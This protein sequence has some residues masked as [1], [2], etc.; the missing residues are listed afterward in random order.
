MESIRQSQELKFKAWYPT[1]GRK[2]TFCPD[3]LPF[4]PSIHS[5]PGSAIDFLCVLRRVKTHTHT[6][7]VGI[8]SSLEKIISAL[9][10]THS[11]THLYCCSR[12]PSVPN[13]TLLTTIPLRRNT[14]WKTIIIII[15]RWMD[16]TD[17]WRNEGTDKRTNGRTDGWIDGKRK[18][19]AVFAWEKMNFRFKMQRNMNDHW[20]EIYVKQFCW[21][22]TVVS[23]SLSHSHTHTMLESEKIIMSQ[24]GGRIMMRKNE[25]IFRSS[26]ETSHYS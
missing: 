24:V 9:S 11:F 26:G 20:M 12:C 6:H 18:K 8:F 4:L 13:L 15:M 10:L 1:L 22:A 2:K 19:E 14:N 21:L 3:F 23:H 7:T 25:S 16:R 5:S 17:G